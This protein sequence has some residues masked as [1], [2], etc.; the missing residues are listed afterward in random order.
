MRIAHCWRS[1]GGWKYL[2]VEL[3]SLQQQLV[4]GWVHS[5]ARGHQ[6]KHC[7]SSKGCD[8]T[9]QLLEGLT[10]GALQGLQQQLNLASLL[11][12][13]SC[14]GCQQQPQCL[15]RKC[16]AGATPPSKLHM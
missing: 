5:T 7:F 14:Q 2:Y 9:W 1:T 15:I 12:A 10:N 16:P 11:A 6:H 8:D 3:R 4:Q 13:A